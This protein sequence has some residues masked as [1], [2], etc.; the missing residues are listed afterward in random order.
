VDLP[1]EPQ[2]GRHLAVATALRL[3]T[4]TPLSRAPQ[5]RRE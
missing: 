1:A 2:L 4:A 3:R 5:T